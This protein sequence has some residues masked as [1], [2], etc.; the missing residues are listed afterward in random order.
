MFG[1]FEVTLVRHQPLQFLEEALGNRRP[2][3]ALI[4]ALFQQ[5]PGDPPHAIGAKDAS[6]RLLE[7][8]LVTTL[9]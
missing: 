1:A 6:E 5:H 2:S 3:L 8:G 7:G 4:S 9:E